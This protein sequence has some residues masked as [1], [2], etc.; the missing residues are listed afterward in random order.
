MMKGKYTQLRLARQFREINTIVF[1][2]PN[3]RDKNNCLYT[4]VTSH[5][6][7]KHKIKTTYEHNS[8]N[9]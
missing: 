7:D 4:D 2:P 1:I 3:R 6:N 8:T 9:N 5:R